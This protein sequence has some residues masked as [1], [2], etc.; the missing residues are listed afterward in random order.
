MS[1][2]DSCLL[3][4]AVGAA[5]GRHL[6]ADIVRELLSREIFNVGT[7]VGGSAVKADAWR[8]SFAD[9]RWP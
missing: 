6:L 9:P 2:R 1:H 4:T 7:E 3:V 8:H 5:L